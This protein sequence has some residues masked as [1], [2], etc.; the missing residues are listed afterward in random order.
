MHEK[1]DG[2]LDNR[3]NIFQ[4]TNLYHYVVGN[5]SVIFDGRYFFVKCLL[6]YF[7]SNIISP[8]YFVD[9]IFARIFDQCSFCMLSI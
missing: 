2:R 7:L 3:F 8:D 6:G 1:N 4:P 9:F 5:V